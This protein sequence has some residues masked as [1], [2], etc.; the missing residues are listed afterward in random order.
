MYGACVGLL[1]AYGSASTAFG[2]G[3]M[4][5]AGAAAIASTIDSAAGLNA[6]QQAEAQA[7]LANAKAALARLESDPRNALQ[8]AGWRLDAMTMLLSMPASQIKAMNADNS[9]SGLSGMRSAAK[10]VRAK[11]NKTD[12]KALGDLNG[13]LV[14]YPIT[15]C[16]N[17]DTRNAGGP[18]AGGTARAFDADLS[19]SQGGVA[20]CFVTLPS[21]ASAWAMNLTVINMNTQGFVAVR[22]KG[23][24]NLTSLINYTG[25]GQQVNN[26]VIVQNNRTS[27]SEWEVY[28]ATTVDV[29]IDLFGYFS[30]PHKTALDCTEVYAA[31][32]V[33]IAPG[34]TVCTSAVGTESTCAA[35][36]S[37]V[38]VVTKWIGG[39]NGAALAQTQTDRAS[40]NFYQACWTNNGGAISTM[41]A[42]MRCCRTPGQ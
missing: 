33:T 12:V 14:F 16:R 23:S 29:I 36:Y 39:A 3:G 24:S 32:N 42:G 10:D 9:W 37:A 20:G 15:P 27:G 28:A 4:D 11:A 31:N 25:P 35:G 22:S 8:G 38:S 21:D 41:Q 2:Q 18:I 19:S 17:A 6:A 1:L 40:T 34:A 7:R 26:F 13:D 5:P 30:P